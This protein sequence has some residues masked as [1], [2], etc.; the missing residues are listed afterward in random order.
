MSEL[1]R[2]ADGK[3]EAE[4]GKIA[5]SLS[6]QIEALKRQN[7]AKRMLRSGNTVLEV[8]NLCASALE[9]LKDDILKQY[10]WAASKSLLTS[11]TFVE[12][13]IR[14]SREQMQPLYHDSVRH[15]ESAIALAGAPNALAECN[16]KLDAKREQTLNDIAL[17]LRASFAELKRDRVRNLCSAATGWVSKLFGGSPKP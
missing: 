4:C 12:E 15:L 2:L 5:A 13:L 3:M 1:K 10:S 14:A 11:Q 7:A 9:S 16:A 6:A 8:V 17:A